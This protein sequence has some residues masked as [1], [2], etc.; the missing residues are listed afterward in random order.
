MPQPLFTLS[1]DAE[2][3]RWEGS[4]SGNSPCHRWEPAVVAAALAAR[5]LWLWGVGFWMLSSLP[6]APLSAAV[7]PT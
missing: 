3:S 4:R 7:G 6:S 5:P 2:V 1:C